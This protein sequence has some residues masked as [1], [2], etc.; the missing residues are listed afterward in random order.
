MSNFEIKKELNQNTNAML[1]VPQNKY[2]EYVTNIL[3]QITNE[4][5]C[6]ITLNR[7]CRAVR[8]FLYKNNINTQKMLTKLN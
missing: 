3:K 1:L 6:Y 2:D 7:T 5:I 4:K 8:E